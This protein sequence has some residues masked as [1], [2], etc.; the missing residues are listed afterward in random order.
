MS[1]ILC[2]AP[3]CGKSYY[4][5]RLAKKLN[6]RF[7]DTDQLIE[8]KYAEIS[9]KQL[10]CRDI[11]L[12][13]GEPYFRH[14]ESSIIEE[15]ASK[16]NL[17][18]IAIGGGTLLNSQNASVLKSIGKLVFLNPPFSTLWQ[19]LEKK[20]P[21]PSYIDVLDPKRSF[22]GI[23]AARLA[24]CAVHAHVS[25][26]IDHQNDEQVLTWLSSHFNHG[27]KG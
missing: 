25:L 10:S 15:L 22:E 16:K 1:L 8:K 27:F 13:E 17:A 21:L 14:L 2:G 6:I 24:A 9:Y 12:R 11:T 19:R 3:F 26:D 5:Q 23:V 4:G 20:S 18:V 7:V